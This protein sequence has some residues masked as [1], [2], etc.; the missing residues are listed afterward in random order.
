[1]RGREGLFPVLS[2]CDSTHMH[3]ESNVHAKLLTYI[4]GRSVLDISEG[5]TFTQSRDTT[6]AKP[7]ILFTLF[8]ALGIQV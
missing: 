7:F 2:V 3:R 1:M 4:T 8:S 5:E 6:L